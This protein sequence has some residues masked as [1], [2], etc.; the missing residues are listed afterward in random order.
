[1]LIGSLLFYEGDHKISAGRSRKDFFDGDG[2]TMQYLILVE[3]TVSASFPLE[4]ENLKEALK[5]A[6]TLYRKGRWVLEPGHLEDVQFMVV[7]EKQKAD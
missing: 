3:E 6:E 7:E 2:V 5:L 1:M 4:A